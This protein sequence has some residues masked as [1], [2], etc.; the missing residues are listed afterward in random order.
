[1]HVDLYN[2]C[3]TMKMMVILFILSF[4]YRHCAYKCYQKTGLSQ[5]CRMLYFYL[6]NVW[7]MTAFIYICTPSVQYA[8]FWPEQ[9]A[10]FFCKMWVALKRASCSG[11]IQSDV[12][13][14]G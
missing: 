3:K 8:N 4:A 1:M 6:V 10:V 5:I 13:L 14:L 2:G 12:S 7:Q 11:R 9:H